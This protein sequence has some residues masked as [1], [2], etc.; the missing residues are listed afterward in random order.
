MKNNNKNEIEKK[1]EHEW[2]RI[3]VKYRERKEERKK[4]I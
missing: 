3:F 1:K 4:T 2:I